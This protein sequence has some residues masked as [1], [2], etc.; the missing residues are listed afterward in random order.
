MTTA[1]SHFLTKYNMPLDLGP[2]LG[3]LELGVMFSSIL[4]G[5]LIVQLYNYS[6]LNFVDGVPVR[7]LVRARTY[8]LIHLREYY[9]NVLRGLCITIAGRSNVRCGSHLWPL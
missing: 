2:L 7:A 8:N 9:S 3:S 4:Y 1:L 5:V 6:Q